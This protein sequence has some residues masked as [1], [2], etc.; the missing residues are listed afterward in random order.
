MLLLSGCPAAAPSLD[1]R[2]PCPAVHAAFVPQALSDISSKGNLA[3][4]RFQESTDARRRRRRRPALSSSPC[5]HYTAFC[6]KDIIPL[7]SWAKAPII[8]PMDRI[9]TSGNPS[10]KAAAIYVRVSTADQHVESQL[11]DLRELAA[12]RSFKWSRSIRTAGFRDGERG[13][14]VW[15]R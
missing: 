9:Q 11:Y 6:P 4:S 8:C 1:P 13:V 15:T 7:T 12:R 3:G 5:S 2:F 14:R 10:L